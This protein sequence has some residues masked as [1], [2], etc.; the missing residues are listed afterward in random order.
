MASSTGFP[1]TEPFA[2]PLFGGEVMQLKLA[3][4][5][6]TGFKG[7]SKVGK[8]TYQARKWIDGKVRHVWTSSDPRECAFHLAYDEYNPFI[9]QMVR[10]KEM[11]ADGR[12]TPSGASSTAS[13]SFSFASHDWAR[14]KTTVDLERTNAAIERGREEGR[15]FRA[16]LGLGPVEF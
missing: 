8:K 4:G 10:E 12:E 7:V 16:S 15:V 5:S 9:S 2:L 1:L 13:S 14:F 6:K 3:P 11:A